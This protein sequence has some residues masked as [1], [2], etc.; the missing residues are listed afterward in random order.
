M[1]RRIIRL[2]I[3]LGLA[4]GVYRWIDPMGAEELINNIQSYF[5]KEDQESEQIVEQEPEETIVIEEESI[6]EGTTAPVYTWVLN[7]GSSVELDYVLSGSTQTTGSQQTGSLT[8]WTTSSTP[9]TST[10]N[11]SPSTT[12]TSTSPTPPKT[13]PK[14]SLSNQDEADMRAFLNAIVE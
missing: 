1:I 2:L 3:V 11:T 4:Y 10:T 12:T 9:S 8:T 14:K 13:T 5:D 6:E 7:T